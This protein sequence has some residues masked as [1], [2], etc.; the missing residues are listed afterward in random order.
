MLKK[1][2][3]DKC[4]VCS[5]SLHSCTLQN[6]TE[7]RNI[8]EECCKSMSSSK[9]DINLENSNMQQNQGKNNKKIGCW[10]RKIMKCG[11]TMQPDSKTNNCHALNNIMQY[12][13]HS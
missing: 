4:L 2:N 11:L 5:A 12:S 13:C 7:I 8:A 6:K 9:N 3:S 10:T 1:T